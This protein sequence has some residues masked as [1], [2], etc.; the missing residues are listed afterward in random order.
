MSPEPRLEEPEEWVEDERWTSGYLDDLRWD[1][2]REGV[3][4]CGPRP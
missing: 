3:A 1:E 4:R 2:M